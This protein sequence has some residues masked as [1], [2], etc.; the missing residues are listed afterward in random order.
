ME[1]GVAIGTHCYWILIYLLSISF[2]DLYI[3][4]IA[5]CPDYLAGFFRTWSTVKFDI[6]TRTFRLD[7]NLILAFL[8][9]ATIAWSSAVYGF[10]VFRDSRRMPVA[11]NACLDAC[12]IPYAILCLSAAATVVISSLSSLRNPSAASISLIDGYFS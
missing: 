8:R 11:I 1:N 3:E 7:N 5:H 9:A 2:F 6:V 12:A 4:S 10:W